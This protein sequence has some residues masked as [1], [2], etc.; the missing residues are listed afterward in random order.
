MARP[1]LWVVEVN[2][3][4]VFATSQGA[5]W[6]SLFLLSSHA[7][8]ITPV[9]VSLGGDIVHVACD[10]KEHAHWLARHMHE[11]AGIPASAARAKAVSGGG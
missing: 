8:R 6:W 5:A 1:K 7:D 2:E 3:C 9:K 4:Q 10:D 11:R